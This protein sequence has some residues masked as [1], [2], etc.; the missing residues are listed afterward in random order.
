MRANVEDHH[1]VNESI[2]SLKIDSFP[3]FE[4]NYF[5]NKEILQSHL[6]CREGEEEFYIQAFP[7]L[8][9]IRW[10][11]FSMDVLPAGGS[12]ANGI[13]QLMN[14]LNMN[15]DQVYAFGDGL[16]DIEMLAFVKNSYAM[17][18][19][20]EKVKQAARFVTKDVDK[21]G[22]FHGLVHAGLLDEKMLYTLI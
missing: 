13:K 16:N 17:G 1:Y 8:Y 12:K 2:A 15:E 21:N 5:K 19:A 14:Y 11:E 6:L 22:I 3:H 7:D 4:E 20:E 9:F 18:N 10:H